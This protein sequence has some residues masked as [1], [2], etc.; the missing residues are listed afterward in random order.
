MKTICV[1]TFLFNTST[2]MPPDLLL[3]ADCLPHPG[4]TDLI[5]ATMNGEEEG[6][7]GTLATAFCS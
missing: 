6:G 7:G 3:M 2:I 5:P 1:V 4:M